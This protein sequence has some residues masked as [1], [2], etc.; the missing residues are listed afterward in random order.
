MRTG[1]Y[2][3]YDYGVTDLARIK[4]LRAQGAY[5]FYV[6]SLGPHALDTAIRRWRCYE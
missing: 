1:G 4:A 2:Y 5:G 6:D 3:S